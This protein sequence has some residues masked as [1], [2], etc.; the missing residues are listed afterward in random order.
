MFPT[1]FISHGAPNLLLEK[2]TLFQFLT[3]A[4]DRLPTPTAIL[5]ISAH[6][7]TVIPT[8]TGNSQP[9]T[10][11]DF[12]GFP[13]PLYE[14]TY[15]AP[16]EQQL[17]HTVQS[18]LT[19]SGI[20]CLVDERRGLDHGTWVPLICMYPDA[21]IPVVQ[22]SVQ[23]SHAPEYHWRIGKALQPLRQQDVLVLG[24][25]G[26]TH[27]LREFGRYAVDASPEP[28]AHAFD[29]WLSEAIQQPDVSALLNYK[30]IG[31]SAARNHPTPEHFL[32]LFAPCGATGDGIPGQRIHQGM[33]YGIL[34]EAAYAW[35]L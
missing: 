29:T 22:L 30:Q 23:S 25:G 13:Q 28:Y 3:H 18:L 9:D 20:D 17:A 16:G 32:P 15:P 12:F 35:G 10:I 34:S 27:N 11:Y 26:A 6:W 8:V 31:P 14:I 33:S 5:C 21:D 4:S 1:L 7:D 19:D 24:S 2:G